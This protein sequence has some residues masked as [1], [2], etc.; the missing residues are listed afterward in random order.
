MEGPPVA[1]GRSCWEE[2]HKL[3]EGL[4]IEVWTIGSG[5]GCVGIGVGSTEAL[6]VGW[7]RGWGG[8]GWPRSCSWLAHSEAKP[9]RHPEDN[10][11]ILDISMALGRKR[12]EGVG[13][14]SNNT[15]CL[16]AR[17][18]GESCWDLE[19]GRGGD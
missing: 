9:N 16:T 10:S 8:R 4:G 11:D 13:E 12:G 3:V 2:I 5:V 17:V 19:E 1:V 18:F 14:S 15:M 6:V 7:R